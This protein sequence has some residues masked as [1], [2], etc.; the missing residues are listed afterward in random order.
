MPVFKY[1]SC[2]PAQTPDW[3]E[4]FQQLLA[5]QAYYPS[6][7][8]FNDPFDCVPYV[9]TPESLEEIQATKGIFIEQLQRA[10]PTR[11][12]QEISE[13]LDRLVVGRSPQEI[14]E[15]LRIS[16]SGTASR[17]G[18][19]CVAECV[20]SVLMWSHYASNHKGIAIGFE[21]M[22]QQRGG[23]MPMF[24]VCYQNDRPVLNY[25]EGDRDIFEGLTTKAKFWDYEQEWRS[26]KPEGARSI[27]LFNPI[28]IT[29]VVF[30]AKCEAEV[31]EWVR[32]Q[33]AGTHVRLFAAI[34]DPRTF[35][36]AITRI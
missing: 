31:R 1:L 18:V 26:I 36:L 2:A 7:S 29:G 6:P 16:T 30:G 13:A 8:D 14:N 24:K 34:P 17:M 21:L 33:V 4:R 35:D 9:A 11:T 27:V 3:R 23:L 5:G 32:D 12:P 28:V 19:F 15:Y 25:F 22:A 20:E 10:M